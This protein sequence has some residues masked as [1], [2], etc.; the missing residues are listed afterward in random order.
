MIARSVLRIGPVVTAQQGFAPW[1][2]ADDGRKIFLWQQPYL[3]H[4]RISA[5]LSTL[6][7]KSPGSKAR[8]PAHLRRQNAR[9]ANLRV[10]VSRLNPP[11]RPVRPTFDR[12]SFDRYYRSL[13]AW[14]HHDVN[15]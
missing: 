1:R 12:Q 2:R 15:C 6:L 4:Q 3:P 10:D 7:L 13:G 14:S 8:S 9:R 5:N 11:R